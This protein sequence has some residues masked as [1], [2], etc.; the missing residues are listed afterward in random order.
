MTILS[1]KKGNTS[2]SDENG[3]HAV[4]LPHVH[5]HQQ[6]QLPPES[7]NSERLFSERSN[8]SS[9]WNH[10]QTHSHSLS[11][12]HNIS[13]TREEKRSNQPHYDEYEHIENGATHGKRRHRVSPMRSTRIKHSRVERDRSSPSS[14]SAVAVGG[15][16][17]KE[18]NSPTGLVPASSSP[19]A[20][21][22]NSED[23]YESRQC[24]Q[25]TEEEWV[26]RERRFEKKMR[27]KGFMI[28]KMGEDG[29]CLFR[30]VAD[31]VYGDQEM[32][33]VVR[34]HCMDYIQQNSD[35]FSQYVTEDFEHYVQR[36]RLDFV[37]GNHIEIQAMSEMYN[38]TIEVFCYTTD[39]IN[40]FQGAHQTDNEAI[41][42]SYHRGVHY[43]SLV[44]PFKAT[45]GVG[46]GLPGHMPGLADK[47]VLK[48]GV[49]QS[50]DY[51]IEQQ[52]LEDKLR[53]TDW[54]AT[55][56][57][58]E[59][60]VARES[61]LQWLKDNERRNRR[62]PV[63]SSSSAT[64]TSASCSGVRSPRPRS[65]GSNMGSPMSSPFRGD[66]SFKNSPSRLSPPPSIPGTS[67]TAITTAAASAV[68]SKTLEIELAKS[69]SGSPEHT[70]EVLETA[71]FMNQIPPEMFGL[72]EWE[73]AG[74]LAKVLAA[75][76]Q[77]YLDNLKRNREP[78]G[79]P[80]PNGN[81][82]EN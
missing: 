22:Y 70:F 76:Q 2:K 69:S 82:N 65:H 8:P 5:N 74:I 26:E 66:A 45:I 56:E 49:R 30:A 50:E 20:N 75:S 78:N 24:S 81:D 73:D 32:H 42:L 62:S 29:A 64:V 61:Y 52:M 39:P 36:K 63:A 38:R 27:K 40:S 68:Q 37:H 18:P 80:N 13:S 77:E 6:L 33:S 1:K 9:L 14:P 51:Q 21:A 15:M 23:E 3:D 43:N 25:L 55:N 72:N 7:L 44:D 54:E 16:S 35:Y 67:K 28:K 71:T 48:E 57:A 59:E 4:A 17:P 58:I 46:L 31:Q 79:S 10:A 41:R 60:Q 34:K 12:G 53:A 11:I 47:N 19:D